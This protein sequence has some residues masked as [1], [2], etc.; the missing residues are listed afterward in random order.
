MQVDVG[1][2][3]ETIVRDGKTYH[4]CCIG[5]KK[6]FEAGPVAP[7]QPVS[8]GTAYTCPMH[9]EVHKIGPGAC[10][11]CGMALEPEVIQLG[12][13]A[14]PELDDMQRRFRISLFFTVP[15]LCLMFAPEF[16]FRRWVEL[17]LASPVVL[18][19]GW[20]IFERG[21]ASI[22]HRSLN[23]FTLIAIGTATAYIS[24]FTGTLYFEPAATVVT[25]VL[26]GQ[27]LELKARAKTG[28]AIKALMGLA[29]STARVI[30]ADGTE[31]DTPLE[32]IHPGD[33]LRVRPGEKI[34]VDGTVLEGASSVDES[35]LTGEPLPVEKAIHS[36]A[37]GGTVNGTGSFVMRA[38]KVGAG[39][40][41]SR[42]V[43]LV[44]QAQRSRAP[45]QS[46]AD[47][48]S[49]Y[50]VPAVLLAAL[51]T[52]I[53]EH[54]LV[55]A[56]AVLIVACPCALG[57]ATPMSVMVATGRGA[58]VGVL[59]RSA[60]ALQAL[61]EVDTLVV[62]KTGTLTEGKPKLTS[63]TVHNNFDE[64]EILCLIA[65]LEKSS[66]H[67][68]AGAIIAAA[69]ERKIDIPSA[70]VFRTIPGQ[71]IIGA[72]GKNQIAVGTERL[73]EGFHIDT[74][75]PGLY[76]AID[77][78]LAATL[79]V[80]DPVKPTSVEA[81]RQLQAN[82]LRVIMLTGDSQANAQS[83]AKELGIDQFEAQLLPDQKAASIKRLQG[84]GHKV[85]MAGDGIN[86]A[87][88]LAQ[89]NVGI[90]MGTGTDIAIQSAGITLVSGDLRGVLQARKLSVAMMRNI[91]EN[92]FF[93]FI[94]NLIGIPI[95]AGL[96]GFTLGPMFAAAAMTFSSVSVIGNALR[97]R[98]VRL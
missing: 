35:M 42:I 98:N 44:A 17:A 23:M 59:I 28:S 32:M 24:S 21:W 3:H 63:L 18:Y 51:L 43:Q 49:A 19:C 41:L 45:I 62:D 57:L 75:G 71:G 89:A 20:P 48:V 78:K 14:N 66:E 4:F 6:K 50:F 30:H 25:L 81:I 1:R 74:P 38:D 68:L 84:E 83:V 36:S 55:N 67:P 47:R 12:D 96:F 15:L 91:R 37:I 86:D 65:G 31:H 72:V 58:T 70:Q 61:A 82:G 56:I 88:S 92:L 39:T 7:K 11:K 79:E 73:L 87:P 69:R 2:P 13:D 95:A 64:S 90:A 33:R 26:L 52:F 97:L 94:Y 5:C 54:S 27:V 76:A 29:P 85:A 80:T 77:G 40:L 9:P 53:F 16:T 8:E 93:A 10:P 34:P 46:L 60:D 22:V